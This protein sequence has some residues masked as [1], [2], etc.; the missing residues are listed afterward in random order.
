MARQMRSL[1]VRCKLWSPFDRKLQLRG[2][3]L[4]PNHIVSDSSSILHGL[5]R[6]W[7]PVF[8]KKEVDKT[9]ASA[10]AE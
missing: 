9:A 3:R 8:A 6:H 2:L 5:A 10:R 4:G 1:Q 7:G